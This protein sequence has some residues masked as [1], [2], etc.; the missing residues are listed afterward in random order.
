MGPLDEHIWLIP[1]ES[2]EVRDFEFT[3]ALGQ[4]A[5]YKR[6]KMQHSRPAINIAGLA[7]EQGIKV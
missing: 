4:W 5:E 2:D 7:P 6:M 3:I 1:Y